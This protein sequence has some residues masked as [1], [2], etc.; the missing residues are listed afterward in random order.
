MVYVQRKDGKVVG[1]ASNPQADWPEEK[2]PDDHPEIVEYLKVQ[3]DEIVAAKEEPA[4]L[5]DRVEA[6]EQRVAAL[7]K[8]R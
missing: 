3:E 7:E 6:L 8:T 2:L 5:L 4:S 1:F